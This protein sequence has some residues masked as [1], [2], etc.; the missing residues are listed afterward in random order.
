VQSAPK[1]LGHRP[2]GGI[3]KAARDLGI[4][5]TDAKRSVKVAS[6][7]DE[8]KKAARE[9]GLDNNRSA[10]LDAAGKPTVAEQVAEIHRRHTSGAKVI[11]IADE[12]LDGPEA[13]EKQVAALMTAW[14]KA[15]PEAR[16]QFLVRIDQPIMDKRFA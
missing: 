14:N 1:G 3:S 2:E 12:P 9:T 8:A 11:K 4:E 10:L 5:E 6:L 16:D 15:G 13:V 7:S